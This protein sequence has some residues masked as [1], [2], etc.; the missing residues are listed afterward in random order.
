LCIAFSICALLT[1]FDLDRTFYVPANTQRKLYL[2]GWWWGFIVI[3]A[4]LAAAL[5]HVFKDED[6]LR[7]L[8]PR[9]RAAMIGVSYLAII[10]V[11]FTTFTIQGNE[12]PF[13]LEALYE[14]AKTFVYKRINRIA[15]AARYSET[16][17]LAKAS[18]IDD[19]T[20][21]ARLTIMQ[22]AILTDEE[23]R[24]ALAWVLSVLQ[25]QGTS[26]FDKRTS[27]ADYILSGQRASN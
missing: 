3:N 20:G 27:L 25:D 10:R 26:D 24:Q 9:L 15:K 17:D 12:I 23:K 1:L 7:A 19:I 5:Y 11:K 18:T 2:Y 14:G 13:G 8:H 22:D 21:R 6:A 16:V 4:G